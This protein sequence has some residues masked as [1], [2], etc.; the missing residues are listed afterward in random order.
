M[1]KY[2][3]FAQ[4]LDAAFRAARDQYV[5]AFERLERAQ[6]TDYIARTD[7]F[8]AEYYVGEN[9]RK[10]A[11]AATELQDAKWNFKDVSGRVWSVFNGER[12]KIHARL[13]VTVRADS[14]ANPDKVDLAGLELLKSG[15][16]TAE[17]MEAMLA[18]YDSN[19]TMLKLLAKYADI[20]AKALADSGE[21]R[22]ERGRFIG[23]HLAARDG[24]GKVLRTW[25]ELSAVADYCS[26][27]GRNRDPQ[28][29]AAMCRNW[30]QLSKN[31]IDKF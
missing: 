29:I 30:E 31:M 3:Y 18:K 28:V 4:E 21:D 10:K 9:E 27:Q 11:Q 12:D 13:T 15:V 24:N 26:G 22:T 25:E 6:S 14:T 8:G 19:P 1:S 17:D 2:K 16:M 7:G 23:V 5:K 20:Q